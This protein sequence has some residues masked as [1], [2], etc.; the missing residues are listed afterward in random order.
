MTKNDLENLGPCLKSALPTVYLQNLNVSTFIEVF[1][2]LSE[3]FQPDTAD[4]AVVKS[5]IM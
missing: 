1:S 3:I 2:T 4:V 5:F